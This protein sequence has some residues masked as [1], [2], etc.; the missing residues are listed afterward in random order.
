MPEEVLEIK[1]NFNFIHMYYLGG[2]G[3]Q[4]HGKGQ[5]LIGIKAVNDYIGLAWMMAGDQ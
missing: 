4:G 1:A 2:V 5:R 3:V